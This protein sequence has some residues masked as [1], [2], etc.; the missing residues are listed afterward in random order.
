MLQVR[1]DS[2]NQPALTRIYVHTLLQNCLVFTSR[3]VR[4]LCSS[5]I[6]S[7]QFSMIIKSDLN[8][9][10]CL[11]NII[12]QILQVKITECNDLC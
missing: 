9:I 2:G 11:G 5:H 4:S 1:A 3:P 12:I 10:K 7:G 6:H 8:E